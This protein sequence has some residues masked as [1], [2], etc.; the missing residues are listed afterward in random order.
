V[1]T[2]KH[3]RLKI[4]LGPFRVRRLSKLRLAVVTILTLLI[5]SFAP[6]FTRPG[7][8]DPDYT[9]IPMSTEASGIRQRPSGAIGFARDQFDPHAS[10][11]YLVWSERD[12]SLDASTDDLRDTH[13]IASLNLTGSTSQV[14][15]VA[16]GAGNQTEPAISGSTV[17]WQ[18][19]GHSCPTCEQDIRGKDLVTG[20]TF[21]VATG[22]NDQ[23]HPAIAGGWV[24][25]IEVKDATRT[26]PDP[27][28]RLLV[29]H[30]ASDM[31]PVQIAS[32]SLPSRTMMYRPVMSEEYVVWTEMTMNESEEGTTVP[33]TVLRAYNLLTGTTT[34]VADVPL[35][36]LEYALAD[37]RVVWADGYLHLLDLS[38]NQQR[39]LFGMS[40]ATPSIKNNYV[41]WS[42][43]SGDGAD[44]LDIWG[45]DLTSASAVP[46]LLFSATG[47]QSGAVIANDTLIWQSEGG[48]Y[49]DRAVDQDRVYTTNLSALFA[50]PISQPVLEGTP[51][52]PVM[53]KMED[54]GDGSA[55]GS[56]TPSVAHPLIKGMHAA[57]ASGWSNPSPRQSA[58]TDALANT[59]T[60]EAYFGAVLALESDLYAWDSHAPG[61]WGP[62]VANVMRSLVVESHIEVI[63]RS[64]STNP[65]YAWITNGPNPNGT[66]SP[67]TRASQIMNDLTWRSWMRRIQVENEPD[68]EWNSPSNLCANPPGCYW[69]DYNGNPSGRYVWSNTQDY[70]L[71]QAINDWYWTI[72][73][74]IKNNAQYGTCNP[75]DPGCTYL[76]N[77]QTFWAPPLNPGLGYKLLDNRLSRYKY[78]AGML[79]QFTCGYAI[80]PNKRCVSY[81]LY[82]A[83]SKRDAMWGWGIRNNTFDWMNTTWQD[84]I[85]NGTIRSM[86]TEFG[87]DPG[88]MSVCGYTQDS[89]W[90]N[91][92]NPDCR[93]ADGAPHRFAY[94]P[95]DPPYYYA[96]DIYTIQRYYRRKAETIVV[97]L[98]KGWNNAADGLDST[99]SPKDWFTK[100]QQSTPPDPHPWCC[101]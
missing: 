51:P 57:N 3:Q 2:I 65:N 85:N 99:G 20:Q 31:A 67:Y 64:N 15:A 94:T 5:P 33:R 27:T 92:Q 43:T 86:I 53:P 98:T 55:I 1:K 44:G 26:I 41:T 72:R 36:T 11:T 48:V 35:Y 23:S 66:S 56:D 40:G 9:A 13:D 14:V 87:W 30:P 89:V 83:P 52:A 95:D 77:N 63:V 21:A 49:E 75:S 74:I 88:A 96:G 59:S 69:R 68:D 90:Q 47:N 29:A 62:K 82:P 97:W 60:N 10:D 38:T 4:S 42:A 54:T 46:T 80:D 101:Q 34:T 32:V 79:T 22:P 18:D 7:M 12:L 91:N 71:Y 24:A 28:Q 61:S 17:V 58:S 76:R 25:W 37:H 81:H 39:D 73:T 6:G 84:G 16:S 100:Y 70:R 93:S 50:T 19:N 45:I 8:A 78:L